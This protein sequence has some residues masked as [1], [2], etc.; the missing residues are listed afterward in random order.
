MS[1]IISVVVFLAVLFVLILVHEWGH[2]ITAKLTGMRVDEFGIGF[3]PKLLSFKRGETNYTLNALPVGGFVKIY[4]ENPDELEV[5]GN[6]EQINDRTRAFG[7][8]PKWAQIMVLLA[9]VT[10]NMALAWSLLFVILL[11]GVQSSVEEGQQ[12]DDAKLVITDVMVGGP[13]YGVLPPQSEVVSVVAGDKE[14]SDLIP[15]AFSD[16]IVENADTE[17][18]ITYILKNENS[19]ATLTPHTGVLSESS[20]RP[21]IGV[22]LAL[23][24]IKHYSL[25]EAISE[26]SSQT[27]N[28]TKAITSGLGGL[29]KGVVTGTADYSQ[30]SGPIGIVSYVGDAAA[31]GFTSLLYFMA[32]ISINLAVINLLP[33]P[34][35]D[36]GRIIFVAIEAIIRRPLNQV[37]AGRVNLIGFVLLM[38]LML[39]V[40]VHDVLRLW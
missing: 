20:S 9:G 24:E 4:G 3:P 2:Y 19:T 15:S 16:F 10:M 5:G 34:A 40:T 7:A 1:I 33:V 39:L 14:L 29:L 23:V 8:R 27:V 17:I 22:A 38:L 25:L 26:A 12:N 35:L 36:G 6:D 32:I 21:A 13:A 28:I 37:W 30:V 18:A 31:I 11:A